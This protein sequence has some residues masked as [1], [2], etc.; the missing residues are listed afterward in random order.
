MILPGVNAANPLSVV[1]FKNTFDVALDGG[2]MTIFDEETCIGEAMLE[3]TRKGDEK[4]RLPSTVH[5]C[6]TSLTVRRS[7]SSS[8]PSGWR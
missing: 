8:C 3:T 7:V 5:R 6:Q 4:V 1:R 2:P